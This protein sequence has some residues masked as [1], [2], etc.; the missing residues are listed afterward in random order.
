MVLQTDEIKG[1]AKRGLT[2]FIDQ[3][4]MWRD[5]LAGGMPH[6][7]LAETMLEESGYTDMLLKDRSPQAQTRLD[8]LKEL[9]NAIGQ[10]DSLP[11]FLEHVELVMDVGGQRGGE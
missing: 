6:T 3:I 1:A 5:K 7:E 8:N 4:N 9:I 11:A 2:Q 10:F